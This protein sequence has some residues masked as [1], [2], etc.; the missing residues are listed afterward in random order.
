LEQL[1]PHGRRAWAWL[2]GLEA[3]YGTPDADRTYV[4]ACR[5]LEV[6]PLR[7]RL[8]ALT[9]QTRQGGLTQEELDTII[10]ERQRLT[11]ELVSRYPEELLKR[12]LRRED[13]DAR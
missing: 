4:D 12:K 3:K 9:R 5:A 11:R 2:G 8:A 1:S 6:R 13:V 7:R 10:R